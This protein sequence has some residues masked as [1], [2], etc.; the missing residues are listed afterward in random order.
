MFE[1]RL[2][3]GSILKK[4]VDS[5]KEL[6]NEVNFDVSPTGIQ[7]Q[8]MDQSHVCLVAFQLRS[9]GFEHYRCDRAISLGVHLGNLAKILKCAGE[10]HVR[11]W[12]GWGPGAAA[13]VVTVLGG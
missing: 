3:Q 10:T 12:G 6:V 1:A 2:A 13:A 9:D 4:M 8:N 5:L 7:M 11:G